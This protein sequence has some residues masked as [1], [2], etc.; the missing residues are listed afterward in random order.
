[1]VINK[2]TDTKK[3]YNIDFLRFVFCIVIV[4]YHILHSNIISYTASSSFYENLAAQSN[5]AGGLVICFFILSGFFLY[6]SYIR[7]P[8]MPTG[9]FVLKKIARLWGV[10]A[11]YTVITAVFFKSGVYTSIM[12]V[13]FLQ[14]VGLSSNQTGINW[15]VSPL[16]WTLIFY[17]VLAKC[18]KKE[19][20]MN[21][22]TAVLSYFSFVIVLTYN[23]FKLSRDT[24]YGVFSLSELTAVGCIGAG[25]LIAAALNH[26]YSLDAIKNF[27][28]TKRRRAAL[29]LASSALEIG[30]AA[31]LGVF[32]FWREKAGDNIFIIVI[33]FSILL[34]CCV[35]RNGILSRL[36]DRKFFGFFGRY[37]YSIYIMQQ[38]A[39]YILQKT[40]WKNTD[41]VVNHAYRAIALSLLVSA[42]LGIIV[43]YVCEKPTSKLINS[44]AG[45][46][47]PKNA[48]ESTNIGER[49]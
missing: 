7:R 39:F 27:E 8:D 26:F 24:A 16:F 11:L 1:M 28:Y 18:V 43:Y 45:K 44:F 12:N 31:V 35:G 34:V 23:G 25:W 33:C 20:I 49:A 47:F 2:L 9:E 21:L 40:L 14:S 29:F 38:L 32:M 46:L 42:A 3:F 22:V 13:L 6:K 5:F 36:L 10:L 4:Y 30:C 37:T 19:R 41:F 17:F 48:A 15:F